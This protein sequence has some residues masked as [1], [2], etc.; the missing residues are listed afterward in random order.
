[1]AFEVTEF[2][3]LSWSFSRMKVLKSCPR[4][5]YYQYYA[6]HLGWLKDSPE[7]T[8][9]I[10][11]LKNL[12]GV[13]G[14]FG[15]I[16]HGAVKDVVLYRNKDQLIYDSFRRLMNRTMKTAYLQSL[17]LQSEWVSRPKSSTM[18]SE[19]YYDGD[20]PVEKKNNIINK[21]NTIST[22]VVSSQSLNELLSE[23]D[24]EIR[25]LDELKSFEV[26]GLTAFLKIDAL[27][28]VGDEHV[29]V[30]YKTSTHETIDD[31]E[32]AILY[33]WFSNRILG[34]PLESLTTKLEYVQNNHVDVYKFGNT[35]LGLIDRR[36]DSDIKL[37]H[38]YL[39]EPATN[40]PLPKGKFFQARG[41]LCKFCNFRAA[42]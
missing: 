10:Y 8:K 5:Y 17:N 7:E 3:P 20:V 29:L 15:Q 25:E 30:D 38:S 14:F 1:M 28:R 32:Q 26:N 18:F 6:Y 24:I 33:T 35:E 39:I 41:N 27:Y 40:R 22:N 11:R 13:D 34:I 36:L 31:I 2:P 21:I 19:V 23:N 4:R 16:F 37:I 9:L 42:C 12:V